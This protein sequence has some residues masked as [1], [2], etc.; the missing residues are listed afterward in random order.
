MLLISSD[1]EYL[2]LTVALML[3]FLI[4]IKRRQD[5]ECNICDFVR[6]VIRWLSIDYNY[7]QA[8]KGIACVLILMGHYRTYLL[9]P[10]DDETLITRIVGMSSANVA[11]FLFMFF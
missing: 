9:P 10:S 5:A 1:I 3:L 4:G 8:I 7:S 11:L 6:G 2:I